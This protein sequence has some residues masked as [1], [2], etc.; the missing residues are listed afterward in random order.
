MRACHIRREKQHKTFKDLAT[1]GILQRMV[2][3][4]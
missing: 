2:L 3:W 1:K 4:V